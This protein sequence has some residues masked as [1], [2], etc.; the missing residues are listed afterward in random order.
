MQLQM[1]LAG[2]TLNACD[3]L[4]EAYAG[5]R[6]ANLSR[7]FLV[8][9][10]LEKFYPIADNVNWIEINNS[11]IAG[12]ETPR[13]GLQTAL[14]LTEKDV[15][16]L[17]ILQNKFV[18]IFGT[19]RVYKPFVIKMLLCASLIELEKKE[20]KKAQT[21]E[22]DRI[23]ISSLNVN[24]Y[25][26]MDLKENRMRAAINLIQD[27]DISGLQ[28]F[29]PGSKSKWLKVLNEGKLEDLYQIVTPS[30]WTEKHP[31]STLA[32][33]LIRKKLIE[34]YEPLLLANDNEFNLRYTY[35]ILTM[36][37]G[38]KIRIL[39]LFMM[40]LCNADDNRIKQSNL[41]WKAVLAEAKKNRNS[42]EEFVLLG[43]LNAFDG[44]ASAHRNNLIELMET[45]IDTNPIGY[46]NEPTWVSTDGKTKRR[47]DYILINRQIALN[48]IIN[49]STQKTKISDHKIII[50][51]LTSLIG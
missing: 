49:T 29:I 42:K 20:K 25:V 28:E 15:E 8:S 24:D 23:T 37:N 30:S 51:K 22:L 41:F 45:L 4:T 26:N 11:K 19:K 9:K 32:I 40:Q 27:S 43:D 7:G 1:K 34:S 3:L 39:N 46:E 18:K 50:S 2:E 6:N 12:L 31:K 35:G 13:L 10:A 33:L 21:M 16:N 36:K 14:T 47:L 17:E 5:D 44:A 48:C 38:R